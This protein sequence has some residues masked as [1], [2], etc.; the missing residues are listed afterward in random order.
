MHF[1]SFQQKR[2][3]SNMQ[4]EDSVAGAPHPHLLVGHDMMKRNPRKIITGVAFAAFLPVHWWFIAFICMS[5]PSAAFLPAILI[6]CASPLAYFIRRA[7]RVRSAV[8]VAIVGGAWVVYGVWEHIMFRMYDPLDVPIRVDLLIVLP[9]L[10]FGAGK[11]LEVFLG[12]RNS[13]HQTDGQ[14]SVAG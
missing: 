13:T 2:K 3:T 9:V 12:D 4:V 7:E 11:V 8:A 1:R 14:Q 5:H 10:W 6:L